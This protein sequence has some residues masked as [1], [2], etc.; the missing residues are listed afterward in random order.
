MIFLNMR[1]RI[2]SKISFKHDF[3][4]TKVQDFILS[5]NIIYQYLAINTAVRTHI[6]YQNI[7]EDSEELNIFP[8][9]GQ[10]KKIVLEWIERIKKLNNCWRDKCTRIKIL[11]N[12]WETLK[13][14]WWSEFR[15]FGK[16]DHVGKKKHNNFS[17]LVPST[18]KALKKKG[19]VN[20]WQYVRH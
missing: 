1:S 19:K 14:C 15:I 16:T 4:C 6:S 17:W 9:S 5:F 12:S 18:I 7:S 20:Q 3:L 11:C 2:I 13:I 8:F 10:W